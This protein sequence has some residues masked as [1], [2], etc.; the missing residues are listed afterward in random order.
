MSVVH[1]NISYILRKSVQSLQIC[2]SIATNV[3]T[4]KLTDYFSGI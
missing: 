2:Y 4:Q 3:R 1:I